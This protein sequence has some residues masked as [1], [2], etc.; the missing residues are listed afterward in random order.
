MGEGLP[1]TALPAEA[2][3]D[4]VNAA[5]DFAIANY[6][7]GQNTRAVVALCKRRVIGEQYATGVARD[8]PHLSWS[9]FSRAP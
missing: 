9:S 5:L 4:A 3:G 1:D 6:E 2:D 8:M 7:H